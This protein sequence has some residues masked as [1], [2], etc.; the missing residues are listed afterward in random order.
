[1]KVPRVRHLVAG[2]EADAWVVT[3]GS[4]EVL[5][6][7]TRQGIPAF[8]LFGRRRGLEIASV[9]PDKP[10][11]YA[12]ATRA[13]IELGHRRIVLLVRAMRRLP[14]P[15]TSERAFLNELEAHGIAAGAYHMPDWEESVQGFHACL[16]SLFRV[17]PPTAVIADEAPFFFAAQ[18]FLSGLG[19][20]VPKDVS[21]VC[22]DADR[23]FTWCQPS[24]AHMRWD[25]RPVLRR[26][27]RWVANVSHGK[28]DLRQTLTP[29][30]FVAGGTIGPARE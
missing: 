1:M 4:G 23:G 16:E 29:A 9:G 17:T 30:Q 14:V 19:L 26:I 21:M 22:T 11:A 2:T 10:P 7:F 18:Q 28:Q 3:A 15:G 27:V 25:S 24:V 6:W 8:A 20:R 13:L 5:A 12:A